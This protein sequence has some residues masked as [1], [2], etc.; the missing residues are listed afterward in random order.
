MNVA[1]TKEI[2][3]ALYFPPMGPSAPFDR[4][5]DIWAGI[6]AKRV[7]D[8]L[9]LACTSGA[10]FVHHERASDP[11]KN[12]I[13]EASGVRENE[14]FWTIVDGAQLTEL[15]IVGCVRE[16]A[17]EFLAEGSDYYRTYGS[18]LLKWVDLVETA[19]RS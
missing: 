17:S 1:F 15:T 10:P 8:H 9:G 18:N 3:P 2:A 7:C 11:F 6:V 19:C 16:I 14:R 4:F 5:E 13:A 12:L